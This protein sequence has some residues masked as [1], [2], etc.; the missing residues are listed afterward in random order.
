MCSCFGSSDRPTS[1]PHSK[2]FLI[3]LI[4]LLSLKSLLS[5]AIFHMPL[6]IPFVI[7]KGSCTQHHSLVH[8][9]HH[10]PL[11]YLTPMIFLA[12]ISRQAEFNHHSSYARALHLHCCCFHSSLTF[13]LFYELCV[14]TRVDRFSFTE[15]KD[16]VIWHLSSAIHPVLTCSKYS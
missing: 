5:H 11:G 13:R 2:G 14:N 1:W 7:P 16:L 15:W 10:L 6:S 12:E 8:P 4:M 3:S 9:G